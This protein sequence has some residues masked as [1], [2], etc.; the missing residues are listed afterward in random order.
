MMKTI[1]FYKYWLSLVDSYKINEKSKNI[2]NKLIKKKSDTIPKRK[3]NACEYQLIKYGLY[4]SIGGTLN[5][6]AYHKNKGGTHQRK[7]SL[8]KKTCQK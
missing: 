3:M 8:N 5:Q 2:K 1:N 4:P 7:F 6:K